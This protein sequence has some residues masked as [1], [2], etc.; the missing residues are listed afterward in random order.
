MKDHSNFATLMHTVCVSLGYCGSVKDGR[1][2][3]VTDLIP[4]AGVLTADDFASLVF[5][6]EGLDPASKNNREEI[7]KA[8]IHHMGPDGVDVMHLDWFQPE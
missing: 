2:L 8:F 3:Q 1:S 4:S 5:L 7:V 6:A